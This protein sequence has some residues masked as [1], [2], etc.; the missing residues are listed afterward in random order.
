[1]LSNLELEK[2]DSQL[3]VDLINAEQ[4]ALHE[5]QKRF[6]ERKFAGQM[7]NLREARVMEGQTIQE[8]IRKVQGDGIKPTSISALRKLARRYPRHDS[9]MWLELCLIK[10]LDLSLEAV[11]L[12]ASYTALF[13]SQQDGSRLLEWARAGIN[14]D[15]GPGF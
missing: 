11:M 1:M 2:L 12:R 10:R 7:R 15:A 5:I 6:H 3:C 13:A 8:S 14:Y 9:K 4:Q